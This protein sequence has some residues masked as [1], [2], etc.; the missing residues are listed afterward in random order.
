[1][2]QAA[3]QQ[4]FRDWLRPIFSI[5]LWIVPLLLSVILLTVQQY[6]YLVFHTLAEFFAVIISFIFFAVAWQTFEFSKNSFLLFLACAYFWIGALDMTHA[7]TYKGMNLIVRNDSNTATQFWIATRYMEAFFLLA[8]PFVAHK[9]INRYWFFGLAGAI[10]ITLGVLIFAGTFPTVF[11][12]GQGLTPLKVYSEYIIVAVLGL[13]IVALIR[14]KAPVST[15]ALSLIVF[16]ILLTIGAE[17]CFTLYVNLYGLFNVFGHIFKLCSYWLLFQ[18]TVTSSLTTPYLALQGKNQELQ[19]QQKELNILSSAVEQ[20]PASILITDATGHI[21]YANPKF[22]QITGYRNKEIIGRHPQFLRSE[23]TPQADYD[24][25]WEALFSGRSWRGE[26]QNKRKDGTI[27]WEA[28]RV[29]SIKAGGKITHFLSVSED[30]TERK[31]MENEVTRFGR[32][33]D[34]SFGEIYTYDTKTLLFIQVNQGARKNLGYTIEELRSLTPVD[35]KPLFDDKSFNELLAPLRD[36]STDNVTFTTIQQRKDGSTYDAEVHVQLLQQETPPVFV[37]NTRDITEQKHLE[38]QLRQAQKMEAVG[39]IT[40]GIAHDFNNIL[41][42]ILGNLEF[43]QELVGDEPDAE[44]CIEGALAGTKRGA[45]LTRKLLGFTRKQHSKTQPVNVNDRIQH[46]GSLITKS[47]TA[48]IH[49]QH[50]FGANLWPVDIDPLDFENAI[51]NLALNARDAMPEGGSLSIETTNKVLDDTYAAITPD[52]KPGEFVLI[53]I[54]DTGIGMAEEIQE[55]ALEPFFTTKDQGKGT[56]LGL[57]MVF[58]FVQRS[59]GHLKIYSDVGSGTT[60]SL[61]LPRSYRG[62][63]PNQVET[64]E[65][66]RGSE[67]ILIVD[68]EIDLQRIASAHLSNLGYS[69]HTASNGAE[70]LELLGLYPEIALLFSD[71]IMPNGMNGYQLASIA[72]K[73]YPALKILL[74][75]G[76]AGKQELGEASDSLLTQRLADRLLKKPY[77]KYE[78]ATAVRRTLDAAD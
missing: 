71:I 19:N 12:E 39:Q 14:K 26:L 11:I 70:A 52:A 45:D 55:R 25:L 38:E 68:D 75:T 2:L 78:I 34:Q 20:T 1:M 69:V 64:N 60:F 22:E 29:S 24:A 54:S 42:I 5:K 31:R 28:M 73:K 56:G 21:Q 46:M 40:G 15:E 30:I 23:H 18:A 43:L 41:S 36:K 37:A 44:E 48:S 35:I 58:G 9:A 47:L 61:Y 4:N 62:I 27:Y 10:A 77:N 59:R 53:S 33:V 63:T 76:F 67:T 7:L 17:L 13:A 16:S 57:S 8:A 65:P 50:N 72:H 3:E 66:P 32:I 74:A 49:I 51:L 6:N